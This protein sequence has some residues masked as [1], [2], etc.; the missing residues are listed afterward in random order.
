MRHT[1]VRMIVLAALAGMMVLAGC[2]ARPPVPKAIS[3]DPLTT[4][5]VNSEDQAELAGAAA[6]EACRIEYKFR[7]E[8]LQSYYYQVGDATR[9][10]WTQDEL[11]NLAEA[12]KFEWIGL[13]KIVPPSK[14][15]VAGADERVLV[16]DLVISRRK[17]L[18]SMEELAQFYERKNDA[19]KGKV[20][21]NVQ[22]RLLPQRTYMYFLDAE[23]PGP[24]ARPSQVISAADQIYDEAYKLY[25]SGKP[26]PGVT[27]Y[28]KQSRALE[29]F[30][31]LVQEYPTSTK[32]ALSAYFIAEIYKE[33][34]QEDYRAVQWYERAWQWDTNILQPARF[35]AATVYDLRL[36]DYDKAIE[37]YE[38]SIL[39][40]PPRFRN[41]EFAQ[42]RIK[43]LNEEK[44][45]TKQIQN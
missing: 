1:I 39:H 27:S 37:L 12:Q 26:L 18:A 10:I 21:R 11:K 5:S 33:Y 45:K 41:K 25:K 34:F 22:G 14:E 15:S 23:I 16:E 17:F 2:D 29:L 44:R 35:Q 13:P 20:I 42:Q 4:L 7:L 32:I 24:D 9:Y 30:V 3:G 6:M 28:P 38:Q 36:H 31:Q 43:E 40:D 19:W 8:V